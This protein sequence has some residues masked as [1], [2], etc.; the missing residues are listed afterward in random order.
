[1]TRGGDCLTHIERVPARAGAYADWPSWTSEG[2]REAFRGRGVDR[3][4]THQASAADLAHRGSH[5]VVSTGTGSGKS[6][7]Y[8]LPVLTAL[9][10]DA[11]ATALYIAPTKALAA[12]QL[13]AI[14]ELAPQTCGRRCSTATPRGKS[15]SG[16]GPTPDSS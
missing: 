6:M 2:L 15:G 9:S 7:A 11:R 10:M 5:V 16:Y 4:W 13:R 14:A 3:P 1:M 8:Q 12:D